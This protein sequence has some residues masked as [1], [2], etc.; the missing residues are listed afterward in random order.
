METFFEKYDQGHPPRP[1]Q[2]SPLIKKHA[3]HQ[4]HRLLNKTEP[5]RW[6]ERERKKNVIRGA[7]QPS[8]MDDT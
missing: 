2:I 5:L 1:L 6:Q 8:P 7:G 4:E 3:T